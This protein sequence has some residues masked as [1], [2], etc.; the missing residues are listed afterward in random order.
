MWPE[1]DEDDEG[2][3]DYCDDDDQNDFDYEEKMLMI[4]MMD[5]LKW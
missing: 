3:G 4:I 2:Y 5:L 1:D